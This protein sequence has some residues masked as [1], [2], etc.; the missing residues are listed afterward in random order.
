MYNIHEGERGSDCNQGYHVRAKSAR[1]STCHV[2]AGHHLEFNQWHDYD[3]RPEIHANTPSTYFSMRWVS[4]PDYVAARPPTDLP[5]NG[6]EYFYMYLSENTPERWNADVGALS[7]KLNYNGREVPLRYLRK[8]FG[9]SAWVTSGTTRPGLTLSAD[10]VPL[11]PGNTACVVSIVEILEPARRDDYARW[12]DSVGLPALLTTDLFN[13]CYR[14]MP[15][16][17]DPDA[18]RSTAIATGFGPGSRDRYFVHLYYLDGADP[19][20]QFLRYLEVAQR[21]AQESPEVARAGRNVFD[22]IYRPIVPG[23]YDFYR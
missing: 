5:Y 12:H 18:P 20:Q 8:S 4:P 15:V 14:F 23:Q 16:E 10:A 13:A 7:N 17:Q 1:L 22:G 19:L 11:A 6:G 21:L 9:G 2:E 3:H